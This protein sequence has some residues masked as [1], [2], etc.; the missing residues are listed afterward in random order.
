MGEVNYRCRW[1]NYPMY[2][3]RCINCQYA[4]EVMVGT[5]ATGG[6]PEDS[7]TCKKERNM[8]HYLYHGTQCPDLREEEFM[9]Y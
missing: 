6:G 7:Y 2:C 3:L 1:F 8:F 4:G 5:D 9:E